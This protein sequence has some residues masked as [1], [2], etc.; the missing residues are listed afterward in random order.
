MVKMKFSYCKACKQCCRGKGGSYLSVEELRNIF[1]VSST[2][3][4]RKVGKLYRLIQI[5]GKCQFLRGTGCSIKYKPLS[6]KIYPFLPTKKGWVLRTSCPYWNKFT[7]EDLR[8]VK[9][10]FAKRK[11]DWVSKL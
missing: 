1:P 5:K 2:I 9:I 7:K 10:Q 8:K 6:C 3:L 11:K 4:A